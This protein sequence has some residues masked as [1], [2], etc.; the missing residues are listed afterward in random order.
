MWQTLRLEGSTDAHYSQA[1]K[2]GQ[3]KVSRS[4]QILAVCSG[5]WIGLVLVLASSVGWQIALP[6]LVVGLGSALVFASFL[7]FKS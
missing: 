6:V 3:M 5:L 1:K 7:S 2:G 4:V